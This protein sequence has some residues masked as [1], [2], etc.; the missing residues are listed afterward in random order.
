MNNLSILEQI[1]YCT[2][3][4]VRLE[5]L[6][7]KDKNLRFIYERSFARYFRV[8]QNLILKFRMIL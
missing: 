5:Y 1:Q 2:K 8:R 3:K 6:M 7:I 4:M